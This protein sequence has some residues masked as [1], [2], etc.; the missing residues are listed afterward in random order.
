MQGLLGRV[1][2]STLP[3]NRVAANL[4]LSY[5][6]FLSNQMSPWLKDSR[7]LYVMK[8]VSEGE[9]QQHK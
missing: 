4:S 5:I 3:S 8:Q 2:A 9:A 7:N 1:A 6:G